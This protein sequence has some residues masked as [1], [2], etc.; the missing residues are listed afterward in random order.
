MYG[1]VDVDDDELF[2]LPDVDTSGPEEVVDEDEAVDEKDDRDDDE[3][4]RLFL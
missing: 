1:D 2:L 4:R 3:S